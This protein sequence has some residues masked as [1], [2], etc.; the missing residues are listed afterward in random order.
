MF[1]SFVLLG[2]G[3]AKKKEKGKEYIPKSRSGAYAVLIALYQASLVIIIIIYWHN[4]YIADI[5]DM[6]EMTDMTD[7]AWL[8]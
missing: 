6:T 3:S 8:K 5:A 7:I 4:W 1:I 2:P